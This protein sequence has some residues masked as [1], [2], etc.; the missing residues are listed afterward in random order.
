MSL[1]N[2]R[3]L[4]IGGVNLE[5]GS[6]LKNITASFRSGKKPV[7]NPDNCTNCFF[8]WVFCPENAIIVDREKITGINYDYCK[9]CGICE[10]ECPVEKEKPITMEDE[11]VE[12]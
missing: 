9:G 4:T 2:W 5:P 7:F 3:K 8:C 11:P 6:A 12:Y 1:K 10:N